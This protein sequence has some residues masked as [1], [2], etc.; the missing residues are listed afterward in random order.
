MVEENVNIPN[1]IPD[2]QTLNDGAEISGR[3]S[4]SVRHLTTITDKSMLPRERAL[5][6]GFATLSHAEIMAILLGT[7]TKG[8]NV[9]DL[10]NEIL[11]WADGHLSELM[12]MTPHDIVRQFGGVGQSKALMLLAALELGKRA[13]QDLVEVEAARKAIRSSGDSYQL[14]RHKLLDLDHEEFWI[15]LLNN[16]LKR[17]CDVKIS[18]G[19]VA[20]TIVEVKKIIK[21]MIDNGANT[22]VLFHNHPS[23]NLTPSA[24]DDSLT[25]KIVEAAKLFDFRVV[26][27][28]IIGSNGY[29]SYSDSGRL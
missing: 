8:K 23:G 16:S 17:I 26:D 12:H 24:Q 15:M 13:A 10:S 21:V 19:T 11:C 18:E 27:H 29:Y 20:A 5:K 28:I 25:R 2:S 6:F 4:C 7:G 14:M 1:D 9:L 3:Q 22:V